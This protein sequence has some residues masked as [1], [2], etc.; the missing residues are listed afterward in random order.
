MM[1]SDTII[2]LEP[3]HT[4]DHSGVQHVFLNEDCNYSVR[5]MVCSGDG[6]RVKIVGRGVVMFVCRNGEHRVLSD[7]LSYTSPVHQYRQS[8]AT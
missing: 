4:G 1:A 3:L 5:G 7:V 2:E 6:S 8:R